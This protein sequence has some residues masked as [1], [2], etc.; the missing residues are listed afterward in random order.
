MKVVVVGG[1]PAGYVAAIR[2]RQLG[3]DVTLV[4]AERLGGEC[5]N[6]ACIP[7]KALLHAAEAYRRAASS[8][9]ITGTVSFRWKEAVQWKE[10]VVE[11][12]RRGIE[13]LL[14]AAGVEVVRGLAKPGPGKTVEIDGRRLQYDFLILATGSEPVGLRELPFGRRVIGT[15]EIFSL[16]E[17]PASVAIIGGGHPAWKSP[18]SSP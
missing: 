1:G 18:P 5:T 9:W 4:E 14:S 15:R 3:L 11:K 16:E 10:K 6:Y 2:A 7:S 8:P 17:P 13:F 12:L